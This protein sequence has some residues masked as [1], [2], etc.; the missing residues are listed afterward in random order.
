MKMTGDELK[1]QINLYYLLSTGQTSKEELEYQLNN[2]F[3]ER[4]EFK[5]IHCG[6]INNNYAMSPQDR[7]CK[8]CYGNMTTATMVTLPTK[9]QSTWCDLKLSSGEYITIDVGYYDLEEDRYI[10]NTKEEV[11]SMSQNKP[12]L[13]KMVGD[14]LTEH[15]IKRGLALIGAKLE[16]EISWFEEE[17]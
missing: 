13:I 5:C 4:W 6:Y 14:H 16:G 11:T 7:I 3:P 1:A 2:R 17:K 15:N 8:D 9:E 10:P 12:N